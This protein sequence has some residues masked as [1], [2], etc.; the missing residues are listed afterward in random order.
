L[1]AGE[2]PGLGRGLHRRPDGRAV[3]PAADA[4]GGLAARLAGRVGPGALLWPAVA[5]G[6]LFYLFPLGRLLGLSAQDGEGGWTLAHFRRF[7][8]VP[9]YRDVLLNTFEIAFS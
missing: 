6:A 1:V 9:L 8:E 3:T 4:T 5:Y 2:P 7:L